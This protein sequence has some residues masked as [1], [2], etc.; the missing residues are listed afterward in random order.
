MRIEINNKSCIYCGEGCQTCEL[1]KDKNPVCLSCD[2]SAFLDKG[3]CLTCDWG[4]TNCTIDPKSEYENETLCSA[5]DYD[6]A[7]NSETNNC[8]YCYLT[9][10]I[11]FCHSLFLR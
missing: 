2:S 4:C 8:T 11:H 9:S 5:C 3:K 1:D 10:Y 6:F 7:F